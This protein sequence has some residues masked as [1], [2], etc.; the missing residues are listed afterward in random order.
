MMRRLI[1]AITGASGAI[2]GIRALQILRSLDD[3][4]THLVLTPAGLRT[5][6][7]ETEL[8]SEEVR[9]RAH[10]A[11]TIIAISARR[12]PRVRSKPWACSWR[13]VRCGR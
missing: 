7:E 10:I 6:A 12:S 5:I 1:V 9:A 13:P 4:E 8:K 3:I 11:S 2:Y